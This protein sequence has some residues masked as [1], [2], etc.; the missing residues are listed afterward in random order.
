MLKYITEKLIGQILPSVVAT[1]LGAYVVNQYINKPN[2]PPAAHETRSDSA[3]AEASK[4]AAAMPTVSAA[5]PEAEKADFIKA[6]PAKVEPKAKAADKPSFR[7]SVTR[8]KPAADKIAADKA[9]ADKAAADKSLAEK[10]AAKPAVAAATPEPK[11]AD[12]RREA[13]RDPNDV[14]RAAVER[15]RAAEQGKPAA[16]VA[17]RSP[18]SLKAPETVKAA[19]P[20]KSEALRVQEPPRSTGALQPLPPAVNVAGP[21][22]NAT[23]GT[24]FAGDGPTP[25]TVDA[26]YDASRVTPPADIPTAIESA[27]ARKPSVVDDV[28]FGAKSVFHAV[29]PR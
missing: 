25:R 12:E 14:V 18:E 6:D 20:L 24:S 15:L 16:D 23:V 22:A 9:T 10:A 26:S 2:P 17:S 4:P 27:P 13:N 8:E 1:V 19:E 21:A 11:A 29:L 3:K 28:L 5:I 7:H